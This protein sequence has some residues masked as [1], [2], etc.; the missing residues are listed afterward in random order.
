[1]ETLFLNQEEVAELTGRRRKSLQIA[2]LRRMGVIFRINA[3]GQPVIARSAI[4]GSQ[5]AEIGSRFWQSEVAKLPRL[6]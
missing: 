6:A 2:Q 4:E 3:C 5:S 1:M